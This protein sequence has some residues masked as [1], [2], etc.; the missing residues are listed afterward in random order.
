MDEPPSSGKLE[1]SQGVGNDTSPRLVYVPD[2]AKQARI[3]RIRSVATWLILGGLAAVLIWLATYRPRFLRQS[4]DAEFPTETGAV[5]RTR[6]GYPTGRDDPAEIRQP[7]KAP[8]LPTPLVGQASLSPAEAAEEIGHLARSALGRWNLV[9]GVT[10]TEEVKP[11]NARDMLGA[12]AALGTQLDSA[13]DEV[14]EARARTTDVRKASRTAAG[15]AY[16]LSVL[17]VASEKATEEL[18]RQ[19]EEVRDYLE[20]VQAA[21]R[22]AAA[23]EEDEFEV[24]SNVANGHLRRAA[25][26]RQLIDRRLQSLAQMARE[27]GG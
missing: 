25:K 8:S 20:S 9:F 6:P 12:L 17:Y 21:L 5:A 19:A 16:K 14:A 4:P 7:E 26:R 23:G 1:G 15:I 2:T 13:D 11:A 22:A 3:R 10:L 24:K 18:G 27:I